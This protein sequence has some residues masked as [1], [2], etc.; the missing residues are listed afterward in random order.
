MDLDL[1]GNL[2]SS[3]EDPGNV[4]RSGLVGELVYEYCVE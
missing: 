2:T 1:V 4:T 3:E